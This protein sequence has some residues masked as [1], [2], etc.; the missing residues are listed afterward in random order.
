M[1]VEMNAWLCMAARYRAKSWLHGL[2][3]EPFN[4]F[5]DYI[6][7]EKVYSI[8]IPSLQGEGHQ[9]VKPD[10]SIVL[11]YE[12]KLRK[13][14]FKLV[15]KEGHTLANALSMVIR[16]ADLK[17]TYFTTPVALRAAMAAKVIVPRSVSSSDR[18][19]RDLVT[20][21]ASSKVRASG[22]KAEKVRR[23][24]KVPK[25]MRRGRSFRGFSWCG[26]RRTVGIFV[27]GSMQGIVQGSAI[28]SI[29]AE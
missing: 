27:L 19:P 6:L 25:A 23:V 13:E 3:P 28:G 22:P 9:K 29:S 8:Q 26:G 16:D 18:T 1:R 20:S 4:R 12:H 5:V 17:E 7:G 11:G 2:T 15:I 24:A 14:A 10:W 21:G